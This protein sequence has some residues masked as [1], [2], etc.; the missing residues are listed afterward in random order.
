MLHKIHC[1]SCKVSVSSLATKM[2]LSPTSILSFMIRLS[3]NEGSILYK[4]KFIFMQYCFKKVETRARAV[5]DVKG[6]ENSVQIFLDR[7]KREFRHGFH[8]EFNFHQGSKQRK[9]KRKVWFK[10]FSFSSLSSFRACRK[11]V[12]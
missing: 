3:V 11:V 10:A 1:V 8:G 5:N 4:C 6:I 2:C 7:R 12:K 9:M